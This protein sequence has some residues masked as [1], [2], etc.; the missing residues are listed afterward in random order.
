[1]KVPLYRHNLHGA[2]IEAIG[3]EFKQVLR[4]MILSTGPI[5]NEMQEK[6]AAYLGAKHCLLTNNWTNATAATLVALGIGPGDEVILPSM[7]FSATANAVEA[8]GAIPVLVDVRPD[9]KLM[10]LTDVTAKVTERTKAIMPVHLYGQMVDVAAI[11]RVYPD[12]YI[13]EDA[14][15][16]IEATYNG[17]KPG[18]HSHAAMFS[19]YASKNITT[20]EGGAMVT[21]DEELLLKFT[22]I[23]RHGIDLDGYKRHVSAK[24]AAP[25]VVSRGLKGNM[26]DTQALLLRPQLANIAQSHA[27][28][29][30]HAERYIAELANLPVEI[31]HV[32]PQA[33]HAWHIF[34]I[35]VDAN[36]RLDILN[37]LDSMGIRTTIQFKPVHAMKYF[38]EKYGYCPGQFIHSMDW[39]NRTISL[40]VFADLTDDEQTYVIDSLRKVL[41]K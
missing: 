25:E 40:P 2:D 10:D 27:K 19:F 4:G 35:G 37:E 7:T 30:A 18:E 39:G 31:P 6:F 32:R 34:A 12:M 14:A 38:E 16:A 3:E 11:Q 1:M 13:L 22:T 23:Y 21:N 9:T 24:F 17:A 20:G 36:K 29:T 15:Q 28:R 8:V 41:T 5:C 26:P 33:H